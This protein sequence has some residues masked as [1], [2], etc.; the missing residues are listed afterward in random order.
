MIITEEVSIIEKAVRIEG[1]TIYK[2]PSQYDQ[3]TLVT[4][5]TQCHNA[6]VLVTNPTKKDFENINNILNENILKNLNCTIWIVGE[7]N[8]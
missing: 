1:I 2:W 4:F 6:I 7:P 8:K 3:S 5:L